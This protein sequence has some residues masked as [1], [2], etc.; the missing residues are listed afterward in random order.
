[1]RERRISASRV[2]LFHLICLSTCINAYKARLK[3]LIRT[4]VDV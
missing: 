2:A 3:V 1:V 4:V